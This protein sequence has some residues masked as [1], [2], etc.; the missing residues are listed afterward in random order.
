MV[1]IWLARLVV[2]CRHR[3]DHLDTFGR[4]TA[5]AHAPGAVGLAV[6]P[7]PVEQP[8]QSVR[9]PRHA[10]AEVLLEPVEK[11]EVLARLQDPFSMSA[12]LGPSTKSGFFL[13]VHDLRHSGGSSPYFSSY[14]SRNL[15]LPS[16][17]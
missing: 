16:L 3:R 17:T 13:H 14:A 10:V 6:T 7:E 5:R 15:R 2:V 9:E 11:Q 12:I 1:G 8:E 4:S